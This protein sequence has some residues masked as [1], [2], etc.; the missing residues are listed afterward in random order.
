LFQSGFQTIPGIGDFFIEARNA[1]FTAVAGDP[2]VDEASPHCPI[3]SQA[4]G[5]TL[6]SPT[7][8]Q[9]EAQVA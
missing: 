1:C 2:G 7:Q 4:G 5:A 6:E 3:E 8:R 9:I